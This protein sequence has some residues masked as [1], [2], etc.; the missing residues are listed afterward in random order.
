MLEAQLRKRI[1]NLVQK[2]S[3][4]YGLYRQAMKE[5][6]RKDAIKHENDMASVSREIDQAR[7]ELKDIQKN[8]K[9]R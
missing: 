2:H 1:D 7:A 4:L 3:N 8:R 9:R 5:K 6:R